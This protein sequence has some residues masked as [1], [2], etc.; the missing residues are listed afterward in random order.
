MH[1]L[2]MQTLAT[3]YGPDLLND[4]QRHAHYKTE[5]QTL[6]DTTAYKGRQHPTSASQP[7]AN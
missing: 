1:F 7:S 6:I 5:L 3:L 2:V 4:P